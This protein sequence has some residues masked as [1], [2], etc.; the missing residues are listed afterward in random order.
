MRTRRSA[1]H[2][3]RGPIRRILLAVKDPRARAHPAL[4]KGAQLARA[5]GARVRLFHAIT[6]PV[7]IEAADRRSATLAQIEADRRERMRARLATLA[8]ELVKQGVAADVAVEWDF[9]PHE[10]IVRAARAFKA[11]LIVAE[12]HP[13]HHV[14]PWLLRFADWELLRAS[15]VPVLLV[16]RGGRYR[17]PAVLAALDPTHAYA[18]PAGLDPAI[19]RYGALVAAGL[20]GTLHALHAYNAMPIGLTPAEMSMPEVMAQFEVSQSARAQALLDRALGSAS[21]ARRNRHVSDRHPADAI[22]DVA[23]ETGSQLVVMGAI[24]RSGLKRLLVG[25]TAERVLDRLRCDVLVVKPKAFPA[26]TGRARRGA[27]VI[28]LTAVPPGL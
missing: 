8:G 19:V 15:P 10:A 2:A 1:S 14:A 3:P 9:P 5:L 11:D 28:P 6:A 12:C 18:K 7:L 17:R 4:V 21:V 13:R 24:S 22:A 20:R 25:N 23:H 27:R 16:K 26:R